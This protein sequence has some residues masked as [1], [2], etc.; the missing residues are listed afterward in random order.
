MSQT[1]R[2]Y[3]SRIAWVAAIALAVAGGLIMPRSARGDLNGG[4]SNESRNVA[5]TFTMWLLWHESQPQNR[6]LAP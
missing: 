2:L 5:L 1:S 3:F 6:L 4:R